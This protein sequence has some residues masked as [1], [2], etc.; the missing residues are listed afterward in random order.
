MKNLA[1]LLVLTILYIHAGAA[2]SYS[3]QWEKAGNF[4][5]NKQYDSAAYYYEQIAALK[6]RNAAVYYNLGNSYY[7]LNLIGPAVLNYERALHID[8]SYKEAQDN[9]SLTQSR[10]TN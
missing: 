7:R 6:P 5:S 9:L 4:Y 3:A 2:P 8:P 1:C 10:I